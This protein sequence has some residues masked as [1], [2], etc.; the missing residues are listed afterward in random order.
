MSK[1]VLKGKVVENVLVINIYSVSTLIDNGCECLA[2][3][4]HSFLRKANL[5]R[6]K[7]TL[8]RL[9]GATDEDENV[10]GYSKTLYA[11]IIPQLSHPLIFEKPWMEKED[12]VY[13]AKTLVCGSAKHLLTVNT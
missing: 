11:Y 3:I 10:D 4:N 12:V 9:T 2:A 7:I 1:V 13:F 8:R 5:P 6:I